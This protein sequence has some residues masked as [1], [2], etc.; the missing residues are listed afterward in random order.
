[1]GYPRIRQRRSC[2]RPTLVLSIYLLYRRGLSWYLAIFYAEPSVSY[3]LLDYYMRGRGPAVL[4]A[5]AVLECSLLIFVCRV[6][7]RVLAG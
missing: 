1:V 4:Y 7:R 6:A 2:G 5:N 3:L